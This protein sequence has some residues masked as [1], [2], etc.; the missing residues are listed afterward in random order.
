MNIIII[1]ESYFLNDRTGGYN[2]EKELKILS[3]LWDCSTDDILADMKEYEASCLKQSEKE[4][5]LLMEIKSESTYHCIKCETEVYPQFPSPVAFCPKCNTMQ[6]WKKNNHW[7]DNITFD[8][9]IKL[10]FNKAHDI[11]K[12]MTLKKRIKM[13]EDIDKHL[14]HCYEVTKGYNDQGF[15]KSL[16]P[17]VFYS[18]MGKIKHLE[19][20]QNWLYGIE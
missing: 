9:L 8:S 13:L 1:Y 2:M 5:L 18:I 12:K 4:L 15:G 10:T 19:I 20:L 7:E 3:Q 17:D 6:T 16:S 11:I 14:L